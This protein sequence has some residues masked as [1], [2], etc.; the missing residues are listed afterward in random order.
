MEA[1]G[2]EDQQ[3]ISDLIEKRG[4]RRGCIAITVKAMG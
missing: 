3:Y 2:S 4:Q 1:L